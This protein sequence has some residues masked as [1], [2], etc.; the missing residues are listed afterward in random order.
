M[1]LYIINLIRIVFIPVL[2]ENG[3]ALKATTL[4]KLPGKILLT[5]QDK[6]LPIYL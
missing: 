5:G 6:T 2:D 3:K 4:C 1:E